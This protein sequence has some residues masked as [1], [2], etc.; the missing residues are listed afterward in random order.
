M[1]RTLIFVFLVYC[2]PVYECFSNE[3]NNLSITGV[4]SAIFFIGLVGMCLDACLGYIAKLVSY[5]E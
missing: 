1:K 5:E 3:W 4:I 2:L